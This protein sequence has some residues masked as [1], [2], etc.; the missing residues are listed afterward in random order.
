MLPPPSAEEIAALRRQGLFGRLAFPVIGPAAI[1]WMRAVRQNRVRGLAEVRSRFDAIV[2][3]GRPLVI[4]ANHLTMVDSM[5]LHWSLSSP[6]AYMRRF[7]SFAWNVP[8][9]EN[10]KKSAPIAAFTYLTKT[11]AI[12]RAGDP[13]HHREVLGKLAHLVRQ[14]EIVTIFPEGGRSRTGR[15]EPSEVT[16]GVGQ[17]LGDVPDALV[18]CVYLR[19]ERQETWGPLPARGDV[20]DVDLRAIEPCTRAQGLRASR[21]RAR[22]IILELK[23][24]EDRWFARRR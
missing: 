20:I 6:L 10:F 3:T 5:F 22:Q 12:D 23:D 21:D 9:V 14:G 2:R 13:E 7:R 1:F 19:G 8:A 17:L 16:Y 11:I 4:C 15:V 24:M 18:V